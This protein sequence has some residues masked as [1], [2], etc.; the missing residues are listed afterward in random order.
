MIRYLA[1]ALTLIVSGLWR[2]VSEPWVAEYDEH[3]RP[4][5]VTRRAP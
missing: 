3:G 1:D 2:R 5:R 4:K